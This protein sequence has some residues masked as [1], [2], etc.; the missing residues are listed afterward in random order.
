MRTSE[1]AGDGRR[2]EQHSLAK[3]VLYNS[4]TDELTD[5]KDDQYDEQSHTNE[6]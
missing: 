5:A 2:V 4:T 3:F 6:L 1:D